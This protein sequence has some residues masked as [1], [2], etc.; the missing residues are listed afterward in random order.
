MYLGSV[1]RHKILY[2]KGKI[3]YKGVA[4]FMFYVFVLVITRKTIEL[5]ENQYVDSFYYQSRYI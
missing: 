2:E 1:K 4:W 5:Q 3:H